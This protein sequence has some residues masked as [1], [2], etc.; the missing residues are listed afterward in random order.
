MAINILSISSASVYNEENSSLE[1]YSDRCSNSSQYM[2]SFAS[3]SD[4]AFLW[5]KSALLSACSASRINAPTAVPL[6]MICLL[7]TNSLCPVSCL[8]SAMIRKAKS[9]DF[10][11]MMFSCGI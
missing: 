5:I 1:I 3:L 11:L 6:R 9:K 2:V 8:F 4:M 7:I 10:C